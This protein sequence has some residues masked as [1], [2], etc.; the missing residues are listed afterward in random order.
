MT[1]LVWTLGLNSTVVLHW[2][3]KFVCFF[4]VVPSRSPRTVEP[5]Q[6]VIIVV[7]VIV[8][9]VIVIVVIVIV[10]VVVVVTV[11]HS[12]Q[13]GSDPLQEFSFPLDKESP[14]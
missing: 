6:I 10:I 13:M 2:R 11:V 12:G 14:S 5:N 1:I 8:V 9:I 4:L 3:I 7:V